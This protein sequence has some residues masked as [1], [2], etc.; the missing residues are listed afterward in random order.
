M[1]S[2]QLSAISPQFLKKFPPSRQE[3]PGIW[4]LLKAEGY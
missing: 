1:A 3:K 2:Y 4:L